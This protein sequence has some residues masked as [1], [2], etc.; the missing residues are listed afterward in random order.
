MKEE[1]NKGEKGLALRMQE[2][3]REPVAGRVR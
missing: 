3:T 2:V 1:V